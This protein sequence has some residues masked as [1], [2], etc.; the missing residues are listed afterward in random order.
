M[1]HIGDRYLKT[2]SKHEKTFDYAKFD[3]IYAIF[4]YLN[5]MAA[6]LAA[7]LDLDNFDILNMSCL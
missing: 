7:I 1:S 6:I 5:I 3:A 2:I 4:S